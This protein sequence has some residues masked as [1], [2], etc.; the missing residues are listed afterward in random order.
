MEDYN[1]TG[2][3]VN[4]INIFFVMEGQAGPIEEPNNAVGRGRT[5]RTASPCLIRT[6][7]SGTITRREDGH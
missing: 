7:M 1:I 2:N 5:K 4:V 3:V 6:T